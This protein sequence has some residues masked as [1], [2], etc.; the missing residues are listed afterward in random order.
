MF[1]SAPF[2][3]HELLNGTTELLA[4]AV[5]PWFLSVLWRLLERPTRGLGIALGV[6]T[7]LGTLASAYNGFFLLT[8]GLCVFLHRISTTPGRVLSR[9]H[10]RHGLLGVGVAGLFLG[11][12]A[13]LQLGHGATATLARRDDWRTREPPLPDSF[14]DLSDWLDPSPAELPALLQICLLY[15]SPSPRD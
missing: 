2:F 1:L 4:A 11:P 8:V 9:E 15:T 12:L 14:A 7:G 5:L 3:Q 6:M 13:W 10:W